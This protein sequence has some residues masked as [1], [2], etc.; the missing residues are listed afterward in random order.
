MSERLHAVG[1]ASASPRRLQLLQSLGL[2]V[3]V[4]SSAY[5]ERS[6]LALAGDPRALVRARAEAKAASAHDGG[7]PVVVAAD[8][9]VCV[10][11]QVLGK[12]TDASEARSMLRLLSGREHVVHTGFAVFDRSRGRRIVGV[13]SAAV[14]FLP[15]DDL[16]IDA[17][18]A[19]GEPLDK[20]GAYGIQ[21]LGALLVASVAGDFYTVMG[22]PLSRID[23]AFADLGYHLL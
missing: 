10:D 16:R 6:E 18:I 19:T 2:Q 20:A 13:E 14:T 5:A 1:L 22:L 15:L 3:T 23:R 17:Y 21:G 4:L 8:T 7:P 11:G 12:P 9:V